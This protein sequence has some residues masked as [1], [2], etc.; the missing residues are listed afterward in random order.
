MSKHKIQVRDLVYE[1][2]INS[3]QWQL[4]RKEFFESDL[5]T[6]FCWACGA[7]RVKGFHVHHR[8]YKRLGKEQLHDLTLL[9]ERCHSAVHQLERN[10]KIGL[11]DATNKFIKSSRKYLGLDPLP[12]YLFERYKK[13]VKVA[14]LS[15]GVVSNGQCVKILRKTKKRASRRCLVSGR[16]VDGFCGVH[17]V[18]S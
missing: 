17:K 12:D 7:V 16:L 11:F 4:K 8:T 6:H 18:K 5:P 1:T 15:A 14:Q 10:H 3:N 9:C 2:Y 13:T